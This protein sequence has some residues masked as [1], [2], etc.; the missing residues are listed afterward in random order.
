MTRFRP[1][2]AFT[3]IELL[4]VIAI[5]AILIGLLLPA[6]QK[7]REAAARMTCGNNLKQLALSA[8]NYESAYQRLPD[9]MTVDGWG[10]IAQ[11]LPYMEQENLFRLLTFNPAATTVSQMFFFN[12]ANQAVILGTG[13]PS[14][15]KTLLCP[16][17]DDGAGSASLNIGIYYGVRGTDW[18]NI[19][20]TWS[21]THLGFGGSFPN[22]GRT[23]YL[24]VFGDWRNGDGYRGSMYWNSKLGIAQISDGSSNTMM[25]GETHVGR[26]GAGT[27]NNQ[28]SY[29]WSTTGNFLAF[30]LSSGIT[31]NFGGAKFG[32]M[33]TNLVQFAFGDGS[34]RSLRNPA[35]YNVNPGFSTLIAM[36]GKS[37]GVI[38]NFE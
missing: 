22:A 24:P 13:T 11:L 38:V 33:H 8:H 7:V 17:S 32:S 6:V 20:T 25:F 30:G 36:G 26:F 1:R 27:P 16:S 23:H 34:V 12:S 14:K 15:V 5:I 3:L 28:Y 19:Q 21:S 4:V 31:D 10:P 29:S 37:D 2:S 35:Q 9:G 18:T